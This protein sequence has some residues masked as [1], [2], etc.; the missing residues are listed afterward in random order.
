M[1]NIPNYVTFLTSRT[2]PLKKGKKNAYPLLSVETPDGNYIPFKHIYKNHH[3][4]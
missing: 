3:V 2:Q 1:N 4:Y